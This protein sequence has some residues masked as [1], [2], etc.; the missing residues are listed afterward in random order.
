VKLYYQTDEIQRRLS[1]VRRDRN[2]VAGRC[3]NENSL[4]THGVAT[5]GCRCE[6]CDRV[7]RGLPVEPL[8]KNPLCECVNCRRARGNKRRN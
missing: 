2:R 1:A 6:R 4:G 5:H 8:P 3:V 7:Y